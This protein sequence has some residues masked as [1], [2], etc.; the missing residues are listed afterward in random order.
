MENILR[1]KRQ[2]RH[3]SQVQLATL[4][5]L[6]NSVISEF[7][8]NKRQPWPKAREALSESLGCSEAEL[9]PETEGANG[10]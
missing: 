8:L 2:E 3:L 6:S 1:R 5:G 10:N 7:E 4:A 9:F